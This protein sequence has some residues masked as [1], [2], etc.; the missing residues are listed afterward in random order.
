[1]DLLIPHSGTVIWMLIAFLT[2]FFLLKK[3]AWKPILSALKQR[4]DSIENALQAA[5]EAKEEMAKLQVKSEKIL[6]EAKF[7][8]DKII[9]EAQQ[10]KDTII[11]D[12]KQ[13][14]GIEGDKI[15]SAAKAAIKSEKEAAIN[16]IKE[17]A[18]VLSISIAE[19]ILQERLS[20]D[21]AEQMK[22]INRI[23]KDVKMN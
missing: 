4:E 13:H 7:E 21:E 23:L 5:N 19:K 1:M 6:S 14:A 15:I 8:R 20:G 17:Q 16:E 9:K 18:V 11:N 2:I 12:A 10:L 22:L 3:F